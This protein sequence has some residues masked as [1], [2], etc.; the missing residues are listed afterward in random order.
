MKVEELAIEEN[1]LYEIVIKINNE[2]P[3]VE[4]INKL[5]EIYSKYNEIHKLYSN[6]AEENIE[7]LKRGLFIQ[8]YSI[9]EPNY[10]T[11]INEIDFES[12]FKILKIIEKNIE[13]LDAELKWM[14]NY[15]GI[16]DYAFEKNENLPKL[17]NYIK[18]VTEENFPKNINRK[19]MNKRGHRGMY[20]NSLDVFNK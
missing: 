6:V 5:E 20:W 9:A 17:E 8:W 14:L 18:N 2:K 11:G 15:Y 16:W 19:E 1:K 7:A 10:L 13:N 3:S 4:N 12:K